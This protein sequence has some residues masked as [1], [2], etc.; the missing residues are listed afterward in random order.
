MP[1][2]PQARAAAS[3]GAPPARHRGGY[4]PALL[5]RVPEEKRAALRGVSQAT[6]ARGINDAARVCAMDFAG[7]NI[8]FTVS[9]D[10]TDGCGR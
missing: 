8:K 5:A 7:L 9:D 3:P 4:T 2:T 10:D 1:A 6:R